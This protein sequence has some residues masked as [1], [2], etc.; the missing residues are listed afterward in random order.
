MGFD[1]VVSTRTGDEEGKNVLI[2]DARDLLFLAAIITLPVDGT[3]FG[4]AMSYWTPIAPI[5]FVLYALSNPRLLLCSMRRYLGFFVFPL[6]LMM[7]SV[8][9]WMTVGFH[10]LYVYQTAFALLSGLACLASLDIAF[11]LKRLNW[12]RTITLLVMVYWLAFAVGVLQW[13]DAQRGMEVVTRVFQNIMERN[14]VPRKPQFLFAEPSYIGMHLFGILLPLFWITRRRSLVSLTLAFAIG[15]AAMGVGVRILIDTVIALLLWLIVAV[16]WS[17][18]Q[19][20][21]LAIAGF[22][23][24]GIGGGMVLLRNARV[25]S[26][27]EHGLWQGDFS[28]LARLFRSLAPSLAGVKDPMHLVFGFG[29]GNVRSALMQGYDAACAF[30]VAHGGDPQGNGEIRLISHTNNMN[31]FFTMNAYVSFITEFG[32]LMFV[33][34]LVLLAWHVS[35]NH[36]WSKTTI[37]WLLLLV[38]LYIQFEGYAFYALWL[39]IWVIGVRRSALEHAVIRRLGK[40][41]SVN[42]SRFI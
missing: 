18:V 12:N 25:Q 17:R 11:R 27:L 41:G 29:M 36:M 8:F 35:T 24:V 10:Q 15:S 39:F 6:V 7:A 31:Y 34:F 5:F 9:G 19:N 32:V 40:V 28:M 20:A 14:Y 26:L 23:V 21:L 1:Y 13:L 30:V 33:A 38:Y 3:R 16:R 37:C 4:I 2:R 22:A 42:D